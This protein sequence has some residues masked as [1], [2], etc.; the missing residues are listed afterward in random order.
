MMK[1][2]RNLKAI[3]FVLFVLILVCGQWQSGLS[4]ITF[5]STADYFSVSSCVQSIAGVF[6]HHEMKCNSTA[7]IKNGQ[8]P[9]D[10]FMGCLEE[11]LKISDPSCSEINISPTTLLSLFKGNTILFSQENS[12]LCQSIQDHLIRIG[13]GTFNASRPEEPREKFFGC[14]AFI[15]DVMFCC[16]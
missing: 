11:T 15:H 2:P 5:I 10:V 4:T 6:K 13:L 1:K 12:I 14:R 3:A 9:M 8:N 16:T 7:S